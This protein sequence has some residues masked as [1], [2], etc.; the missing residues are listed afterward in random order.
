MK[1]GKLL[2]PLGSWHKLL[3]SCVSDVQYE[4]SGVDWMRLLC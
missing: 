4:A 1:F 3:D 2:K